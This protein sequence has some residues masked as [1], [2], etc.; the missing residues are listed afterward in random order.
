MSALTS[1]PPT[2]SWHPWRERAAC[3]DLPTELFFPNGEGDSVAEQ[4]AEARAVCAVCPVR[5]DCLEFAITTRQDD[6]IWGGL[7]EE[8]R[9]RMRRRAARQRREALKA[10]S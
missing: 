10:A 8:E 6:G 2:T 5:E 7:T 4:V 3:K 1:E 9:R